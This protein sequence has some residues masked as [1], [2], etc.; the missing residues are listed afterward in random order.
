MPPAEGEGKDARGAAHLEAAGEGIGLS[1]VK[2]LCDML[3]ATVEVKSESGMG[4]HLPDSLPATVLLSAN[5]TGP[6]PD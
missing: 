1:I 5:F 2:R 4:K 6:S 3:N